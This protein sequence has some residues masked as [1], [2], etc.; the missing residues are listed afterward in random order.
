[1]PRLSVLMP[2]RNCQ[3]TVALA[4]RSTLRA[5][6]RDAELVVFD[7]AS[8]DSTLDVVSAVRDH[9]VRMMSSD[10]SVGP[11]AAMRAMTGA[12]DGRFIARMDADDVCLPWRFAAQET[13]L[14]RA[15][16]EFLFTPVLRYRAAPLRIAISA[17]TA[18]PPDALPLHLAVLCVVNSPTIFATRRAVEAAGGYRAVRVEDYDLWLRACVADVRLA[19]MALPT[20]AYRR[21]A[22][23]MSFA[24]DFHRSAQNDAALACSYRAFARAILDLD[25]AWMPGQSVD[26]DAR[27]ESVEAI[28]G[29]LL[30]KS[31]G[32]GPVQR[33]LLMR[34]MRHLPG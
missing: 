29:R 4:V 23:Q 1:M 5:L 30:D 6:P 24:E 26:S 21:H 9:R 31:R 22:G 7:D 34:T 18:I 12:T 10:V 8:T 25:P 33:R 28:R 16:C 32:L 13:A 27:R 14:R 17:P 3:A 20:Y 15:R 2:A 11:G 19:R